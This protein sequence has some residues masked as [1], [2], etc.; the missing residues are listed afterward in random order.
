M[1]VSDYLKKIGRNIR[2]A[3]L[4]AGLTQIDVY[5]KTGV[6]YRH[7]Q[8]IEAGKINLTVA[9]L[10]RLAKVFKIPISRLIEGC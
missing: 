5:E 4:R 10:C 7:Y 9:T 1:R 2:E 8:N 6:T 3:R